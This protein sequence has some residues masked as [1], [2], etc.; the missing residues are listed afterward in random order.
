VRVLV[1][2]VSSYRYPKPAVLG[3]HQIRL[4]PAAHAR[5]RVERYGLT[6]EAGAAGNAHVVWQQD[7]AGN[8]VA[9]ARFG[10]AI[11]RLEIAV[12]IHPVNPFDFV[13]QPSA[14]T[15]PFEYG[16]VAAELTPYRSLEGE[17][18]VRGERFAALVRETAPRDREP[19]IAWL[20]GL[21]RTVAERVR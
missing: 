21:N 3:V 6:V 1:Q 20:V 14:E 4:R 10:E 9:H 11:E 12:D 13:L 2:H 5:A 17:A 7:P 16:A 19:T 18:F 8:F 15:L